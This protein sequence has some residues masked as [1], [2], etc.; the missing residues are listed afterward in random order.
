MLKNITELSIDWRRSVSEE[1]QFLNIMV[2]GDAADGQE[3]N[4]EMVA[5]YGGC[6][7]TPFDYL[8]AV[9]EVDDYLQRTWMIIRYPRMKRVALSRLLIEVVAVN[10][11]TAGT[12]LIQELLVLQNLW[13]IKVIV[14]LFVDALTYECCHNIDK[15]DPLSSTK[16]KRTMKDD[17]LSK[18]DA[19]SPT[20]ATKKRSV[21]VSN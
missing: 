17:G 1:R 19:E 11:G 9:F 3:N 15:T 4:A 14:N 8:A 13:T 12:V 21:K 5:D 10:E 6:K 18:L 16:R 2:E 7:L 20:R